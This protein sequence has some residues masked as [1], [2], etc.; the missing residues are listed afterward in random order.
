MSA[1]I[2]AGLTARAQVPVDVPE[3]S[4]E[5]RGDPFTMILQSET[6]ESL[7][8]QQLADP[9]RRRRLIE[10][11][12][13][14]E[15][16]ANPDLDRALGISTTVAE[17]LLS[18]LV[19]Q[20][21]ARDLR[22]LQLR[23][24][25]IVE[26][27]SESLQHAARDYDANLLEISRLIGAGRLETYLDYLPT[28]SAR[29]ELAAFQTALPATAKLTDQQRDALI[30][31]VTAVEPLRRKARFRDLETRPQ[32]TTPEMARG[33]EKRR[34]MLFSIA[35]NERSARVIEDLDLEVV[36][37]IRQ[38]LSPEQTLVYMRRQMRDVATLR[39]VA[40]L[41]RRTLERQGNPVTDSELAAQLTTLSRDLQITLELRIDGR[42]LIKRLTST[43]GA[44]VAVDG[45]DGLLIDVQPSLLTADGKLLLVELS[46]Y[47]RARDNRR[48]IGQISSYG[49]ITERGQRAG[50][51]ASNRQL[52][53]GRK[54]HVLECS[55]TANYL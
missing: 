42:E 26:S 28:R 20:Q 37:R 49:F 52:L 48:L 43:S 30:R 5:Q 25:E 22:D 17:Q 54:A 7:L 34:Q 18:L 3:P 6:G 2:L 36:Q 46:F 4:L 8:R 23:S 15:R 44:A 35:S 12:L 40:D 27:P 19:D 50:P 9:E 41:Q 33:E 45:P 53:R 16:A 31:V 11:R 1:A 29:A 51:P 47:E 32:Q 38:F 21:L 39:G 10:D 14:S 55:V 13:L 24:N